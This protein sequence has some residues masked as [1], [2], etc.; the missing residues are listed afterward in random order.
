MTDG[1]GPLVVHA[2]GTQ[3]ADSSAAPAVGLI[4]TAVEDAEALRP[5]LLEP[6]TTATG[7]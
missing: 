7:P 1:A 5:L 3:Y 6:P 2:F 4:S